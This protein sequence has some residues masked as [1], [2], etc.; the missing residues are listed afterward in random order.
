MRRERHWPFIIASESVQTRISVTSSVI[1]ERR[2]E[3][4]N[5]AAMKSTGMQSHLLRPLAVEH[6][7][8][9]ARTMPDPVSFWRM[10]ISSGMQMTVP[11]LKRSPGRLIE[12]E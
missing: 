5:S 1:G 12:K 3:T 10:M 7:E 11:T 6:E 2:N 4:M 9:R 8:E